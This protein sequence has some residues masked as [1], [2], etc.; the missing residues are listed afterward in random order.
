MPHSDSALAAAKLEKEQALAK[1]RAMQTAA[2]E[3]RL[4]DREHVRGA[5]ASAEQIH[6]TLVAMY[7]REKFR[8]MRSWGLLPIVVEQCFHAA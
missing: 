3:G 5:S 8:A 6:A 1:M 2:L 7:K 4:P